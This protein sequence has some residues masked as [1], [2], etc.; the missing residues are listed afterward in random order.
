MARDSS[1]LLR[2]DKSTL[3]DCMKFTPSINL[4]ETIL[5]SRMIWKE[6]KVT[7]IKRFKSAVILNN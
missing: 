4:K 3:F 1:L 6:G 7:E 2:P 5:F